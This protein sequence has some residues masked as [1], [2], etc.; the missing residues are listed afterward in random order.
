MQRNVTQCKLLRNLLNI[1]LK[2]SATQR[3]VTNRTATQRKHF[4]LLPR[5]S[6]TQRNT[7][8]V[9]VLHKQIETSPIFFRSP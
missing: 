4:P 6:A 2:N 9:T 3:N 1:A 5:N 8:A 7:S